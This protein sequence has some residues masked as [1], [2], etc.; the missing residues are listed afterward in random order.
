MHVLADVIAITGNTQPVEE[1]ETVLV[2]EDATSAV[3]VNTGELLNVETMGCTS[4]ADEKE[5]E[6]MDQII[7]ECCAECEGRHPEEAKKVVEYILSRMTNAYRKGYRRNRERMGCPYSETMAH[8][9]S[10]HK[11]KEEEDRAVEQFKSRFL[12]RIRT[13]KYAAAR[14]KA[15]RFSGRRSVY[16]A[17]PRDRLSQIL[18]YS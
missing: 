4:H 2:P 17:R 6:A 11:E 16:S 13:H 7:D 5:K 14:R 10:H 12:N 9:H 15:E 1:E 3:H 8:P 18:A